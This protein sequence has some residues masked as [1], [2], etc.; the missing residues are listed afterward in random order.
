[1]RGH[2]PA[3]AIIKGSTTLNLMQYDDDIPFFI[4]KNEKER[5]GFWE[6]LMKI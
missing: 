1:S 4:V 5:M 3:A 2:T 6:A